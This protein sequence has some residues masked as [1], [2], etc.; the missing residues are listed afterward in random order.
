MKDDS[1]LCCCE[2]IN[3]E[4]ERS[5]LL[6]FFCDCEALDEAADRL[7]TFRGVEPGS[8]SSIMSITEDRVRVPWVGGAKK[9]S[10]DVLLGVLSPPLTIMLGSI[11]WAWC[12]V[13]YLITVPVFLFS[14]HTFIRNS[15]IPENSGNG[16]LLVQPKRYPRSFFYLTWLI[17][18]LISLLLVYYTQVINYLKISAYENLLLMFLGVFSCTCMYLVRELS[19]AG[20]ETPDSSED[21][22]EV[23]ESGA[24]RVCV[25]CKSK[26]PRQASHCKTCDSCYLYRDHHCLWLDTCISSVND[27]WFVLGVCVAVWALCYAAQITLTCVCHPALLNLHITTIL[28][29]ASCHNAF[30]DT[31]SGLSTS[32]ACYCLLLGTCVFGVA[33]QQLVCIAGG[34]RLREYRYKRNLP[35][36]A[37]LWS[38][39]SAFSNCIDFWWR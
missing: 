5:H 8:F 33:L 10:F 21:E 19:C 4:G 39:K 12:F 31:Q 20:F 18:S 36:G 26:V 30:V 15:A 7:L 34:V 25:D 11:S 1:L 38:W 35:G 16:A 23:I 24:W 22:D 32:G 3:Q 14:V 9:V 37:S 27:R 28:Y 17:M 6:G 29:P 2:Y 13:T